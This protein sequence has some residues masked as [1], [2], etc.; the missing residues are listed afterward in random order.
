MLLA[1]FWGLLLVRV[2]A[3]FAAGGVDGA[4]G[5]LHRILLRNTLWQQVSQDPLLAISRG[6]ESLVLWLLATWA[7]WEIYRYIRKKQSARE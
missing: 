7:L 3:G 4:R 5:N 2:V 1:A 6:Y